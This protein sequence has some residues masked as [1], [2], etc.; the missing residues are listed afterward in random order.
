MQH[1]L[2]T[3]LGADAVLHSATKYFGGHSDVTLGLVTASPISSLGQELASKLA[4]IQTVMGGIASP[5]DC[6]LC[7]RGLRTMSVR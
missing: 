1:Y 6:W 2:Y 5:M 3:Q 7:L 4:R